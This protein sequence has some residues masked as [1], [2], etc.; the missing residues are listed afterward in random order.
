MFLSSVQ[1]ELSR[2]ASQIQDTRFQGHR[3]ISRT[4]W[5]LSLPNE[6]ICLT[7]MSHPKSLRSTISVVGSYSEVRFKAAVGV[8]GPT[9][10]NLPLLPRLPPPKPCEI[11]VPSGGTPNYWVEWLRDIGFGTDLLESIVDLAHNSR[12]AY[13]VSCMH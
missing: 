13:D 9:G 1:L 2:L 12:G 6:A 11:A 8:S 7:N 10:S 4:D 5:A 3:S